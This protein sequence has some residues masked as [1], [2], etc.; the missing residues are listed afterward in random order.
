MELGR[1]LSMSFERILLLRL[2]EGRGEILLS[3][4]WGT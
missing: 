4:E 1:A 3:V 2:G